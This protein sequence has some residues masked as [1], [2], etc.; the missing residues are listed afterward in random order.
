M[1]YDINVLC[2]NQDNIS[3]LSFASKIE[4]RNEI[5]LSN[6]GRY[7]SVWPFMLESKGVWYSIGKDDEV[8]SNLKPL[9][10]YDEYEKDFEKIIE[11]L[12]KQLPSRTIMFLAKYQGGEKEIIYGDEDEPLFWFVLDDTQWRMGHLN[13]EVK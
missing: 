11:F 8:K 6:L 5:D 2:M 9:I 10:V 13:P 1:S 3:M 7:H 4:L 12:L